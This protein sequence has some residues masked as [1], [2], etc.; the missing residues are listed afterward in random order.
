MMQCCIT[1]KER[2]VIMESVIMKGKHKVTV[3]IADIVAAKPCSDEWKDR[4][5]ADMDAAKFLVPVNVLDIYKSHGMKDMLW[6]LT[7]TGNKQLCVAIAIAFAEDVLNIFES[8]YPSDTRPRKAIEAATQY[9]ALGNANAA[10]A[11]VAYATNAANAAD[12]AAYAVAY[13]VAYKLRI[14]ETVLTY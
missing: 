2:S 13:A 10:Y 14:I 7:K 9:I 1:L 12:A 3:T 5:P 6:C 8:K 11:A 4:L